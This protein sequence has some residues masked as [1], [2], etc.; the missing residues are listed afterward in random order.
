[1]VEHLR[2]RGTAAGAPD[3]FEYRPGMGV[4]ARVGGRTVVAGNSSLVADAP[5][6][7][8]VEGSPIHVSVDSA[9]RATAILAD[10]VRPGAAAAVAELK[11]MG[12]QV[13][14]VTGDGAG[15]AAQSA[16]GSASTTAEP[17]FF[18]SRKRP[19]SIR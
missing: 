4:V 5:D 16:L 13:A 12:L 10:A 3:S 11:G 15:A 18:P 6:S 19:S 17:S 1:M 14:M 2:E 7:G 9:Y 8:D